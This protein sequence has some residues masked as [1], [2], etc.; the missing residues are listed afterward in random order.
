MKCHIGKGGFEAKGPFPNENNMSLKLASHPIKKL[1]V[2]PKCIVVS[3]RG[4]RKKRNATGSMN[5]ALIIPFG[6]NLSM[7]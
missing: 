7:L 2:P 3:F 1:V 5:R 4:R 6:N